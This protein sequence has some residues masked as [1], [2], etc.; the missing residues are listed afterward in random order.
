MTNITRQS[1]EPQ[2]DPLTVLLFTLRIKC[3]LL[4]RQL[5][6]TETPRESKKNTN[7]N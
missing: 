4:E 3:K 6:K 5:N 7:R 1:F 2:E